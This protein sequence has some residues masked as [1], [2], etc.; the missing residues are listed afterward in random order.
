MM[1]SARIEY[2]K[3]KWKVNKIIDKN[4]RREVVEEN[5]EKRRGQLQTL[6]EG[7]KE[8][9]GGWSASRIMLPG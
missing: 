3:M 6:L 8:S 4:E 9:W 1:L 7:G 2:L 5:D